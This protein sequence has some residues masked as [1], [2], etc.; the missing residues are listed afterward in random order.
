MGLFENIDKLINERGSANILRERLLLANDQYSALEK[1]LVD[2]TSEKVVLASENML[3]QSQL[4]ILKSENQCLQLDI[5]NLRQE[6]QRKDN[7][8]QKEKSHSN[9]L[10][11]VSVNILKLL[12]KQDNLTSGQITESIGITLQ[13]ANFH[14]EELK[15]KK[16]L[17]Q[18]TIYHDPIENHPPGTWI[19][20]QGF[21]VWALEQK[22]RKYLIN[23]KLAS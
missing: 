12:F 7:I 8:I 9:L 20:R 13:T 16:M 15:A 18:H 19:K 22:G 11:K 4:E 14:L 17:K 21:L 5:V 2:L 6:I 3:L 23:N 10:D 1:K